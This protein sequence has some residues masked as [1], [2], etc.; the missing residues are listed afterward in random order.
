MMYRWVMNGCMNGWWIWIM[1][2]MIDTMVMIMNMLLDVMM[3][4][5]MEYDNGLW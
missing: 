4:E 1:D 5:A 3:D 2:V